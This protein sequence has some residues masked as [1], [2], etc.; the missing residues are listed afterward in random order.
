MSILVYYV[1]GA[2]Q[3]QVV[4]LAHD[5]VLGRGGKNDNRLGSVL[6]QLS[7]SLLGHLLRL[8]LLFLCVFWFVCFGVFVVLVWFGFSVTRSVSPP[9]SSH[10]RCEVLHLSQ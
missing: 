1:V 4:L 3:Y 7:L 2:T 6:P 10:K 8:L 9:F 5:S